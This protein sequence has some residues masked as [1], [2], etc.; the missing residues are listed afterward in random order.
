MMFIQFSIF[1]SSTAL[2]TLFSASAL[3][4]TPPRPGSSASA[5]ID[6]TAA[7]LLFD[8]LSESPSTLSAEYAFEGGCGQSVTEGKVHVANLGRGKSV[9]VVCSAYYCRGHKAA[10]T[11]KEQY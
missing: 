10:C 9:T 3:A 1:A 4:D 8:S 7:Q 11:L 5:K 6:G 2:L